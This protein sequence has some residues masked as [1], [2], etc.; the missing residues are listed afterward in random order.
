MIIYQMHLLI[1]PKAPCLKMGSIFYFLFNNFLFSQ[2]ELLIEAEA[3]SAESLE[4]R[5]AKSLADVARTAQADA[6]LDQ[7]LYIYIY[8]DALFSAS[9]RFS[10]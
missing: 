7:G 8:L 1:G 6:N 3:R 2:S 10:D 5:S 4:A 9:L